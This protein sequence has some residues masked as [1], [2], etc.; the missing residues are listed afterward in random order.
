MIVSKKMNDISILFLATHVSI[1]GATQSLIDMLGEVRKTINP[2]VVLPQKGYLEQ[3]LV[4]LSIKYYIVPFRN[5]Y[6]RIGDKQAIIA[7]DV[8]VDNYEAAQRLREIIRENH[9]C[10]IHINSSSNYV[11]AIAALQEGL[12]F[13]WHIRELFKEHF[14]MDFYDVELTR[15][16]MG[17]ADVLIAI[18]D[19]VK[20]SYHKNFDLDCVR[21]YNGISEDRYYE[22]IRNYFPSVFL[23]VGNITDDKGQFDAVAALKRVIEAGYSEVELDL[24]GYC[25]E[26]LQWKIHKYLSYYNISDKVKIVSEMEDLGAIRKKSGYS[27]VTSG[28]EAL[29]RATVESM[30]AGLFVIGVDNGGTKEIIGCDRTRGFLYKSGDC[31]DLSEKMIEAIQTAENIKIHITRKAQHYALSNFGIKEYADRLISLYKETLGTPKRPQEVE[32]IEQKYERDKESV[33]PRPDY[34]D[35]SNASTELF[36]WIDKKEAAISISRFLSEKGIFR[37]GIYGLGKMGIRIYDILEG[38]NVEIVCV[39]DRNKK[40]VE[41]VLPVVSPEDKWPDVDLIIV[42]V[43]N[44]EKDILSFIRSKNKKCVGIGELY[45]LCG[46][47]S[48]SS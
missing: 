24:V 31:E 22:P 34:N 38:L 13:V 43:T 11:G 7:R 46:G 8:F 32:W 21:L 3:S 26:R 44:E 42:S 19:T 30:Y 47:N 12:P 5:A 33:A 23:I 40:Y 10:L 17:M 45:T 37:V 36:L 35:F 15:R 9:I 2:I 20:N 28:M 48:V 14:A 6:G 4:R 27:I 29:G 25:D 1:G 41:D 18:S 39:I 16:L